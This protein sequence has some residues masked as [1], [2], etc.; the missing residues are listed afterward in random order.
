MKNIKTVLI[1]CMLF[2]SSI[3]AGS[4]QGTTNESYETQQISMAFSQP[5][6]T[7]EEDGAVVSLAEATSLVNIP[8]GYLLPKVTQVFT[9]PFMSTVLHV[10]V[11][12][13]DISTQILPMQPSLA[14]QPISDIGTYAET[15]AVALEQYC[16]YPATQYS[17]NLASGRKG[18]TL[19]LYVVVQLYPV[20]FNQ[21]T[22]VLSSAGRA[23]IVISYQAPENPKVLADT[24]DLLIITPTTFAAALE[25]LVE[26]KNTLGVQTKLVT[27]DE[28]C[29]ET[30]FPAEGRDCAE[31][32]KYFI[33]SALDSW[34]I[35]YVLL[36]GGR[37]GGLMTE[38]W[39]MP[40]RYSA[41]DDGSGFESSYISDLYFADIYDAQGN[42]SSWDSNGNG[43]FA[44]WTYAKK[45]ILDMYPD[46][47]VGRLA[48]LNTAEVTLMVNKI[49]TYEREAYGS[50]WFKRFI[51]VAGDTYPGPND[52]YY[53][54]ELA[55]NASFAYLE[56]LGFMSTMVWTSNGVFTGKQPV[57]DAFSEGAGFVHF[58][59]HGN[60]SAWGNHPPRNDTFI[61]GPTSFEMGK[62]KNKEMQ[63]VV[64]VGGCHNAQFNT[65]LMNILRGVLTDGL[66]YFSTKSPVGR[67]WY[68]EWV[69]RCWAWSMAARKQGGCIAIIANT[70][71]GYGQPGANCLT[72]RGRFLEV[73]FFRSYSEGKTILGETHSQELMYYMAE[74]PPMSNVID[75]KIIQQWVLLGDPSLMLGGYA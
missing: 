35:Q 6:V 7:F 27:R 32:I 20:R 18:D 13:S 46:V 8:G 53:E 43:V 42:F 63:P 12:F 51:G 48:C 29:A 16:E 49:I 34:G 21:K 75:C 9:L 71:L 26:H 5:H 37:K 31:E 73:L 59:G 2:W 52:P 47:F 45:D 50:A 22:M 68:K 67:Y 38:K 3:Y 10:D 25:P 17:F 72:Q 39:W 40:V 74:Y 23:D 36:V 55:N 57:I 64:I 58:S 19:V 69:P 66:K 28:I 14:I 56:S 61:N 1:V 4:I 65:S 41:L 70:G 54:G 15:A 60:P 44:E 62:L 11:V 24:Y 33:K 30:Y